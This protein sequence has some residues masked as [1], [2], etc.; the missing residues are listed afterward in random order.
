MQTHEFSIAGRHITT[1]DPD[2]Q[3]ALAEAR[4]TKVRPRCLCT[5]D[6]VEMYIASVGDHLIV[7]RMPMSG[8]GHAPGCDSYEPPPELSGLG[9][10][11]GAA[12]NEGTEETTLKLAF[13]LT[14]SGAGSPPASDSEPS[15]S[16][17]ADPAKLSMRA[18]VHYLWE[19]AEFN[20]WVPAMAGK[21]SWSVVR[22]HLLAA[23]RG[24]M[25]KGAPLAS[26]LYLPEPWND[27]RKT[28]LSARRAQ[29]MTA[30]SDT[31]KGR[32]RLLF[33]LAEVAAITEGRLGWKLMLAELPG[34]A[35]LLPD[36]LHK[37]MRKRFGV[38]LELWEADEQSRLIVA[39]TISANRAG[40]PTFHELTL[41][42][43]T[44][45]WIP[46]ESVTDKLLLDHLTDHRRTF[47]KGLR[48]NLADAKALAAAVL[49]DTT[50]ATALYLASGDQQR[51]AVDELI[52]ESDIDSWVWD[53]TAELPALP[54]ASGRG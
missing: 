44:E 54:P 51:Q 24:K 14:V 45:N 16:V 10:V 49:T 31:S 2:W 1:V 5:R 21:R 43:V 52:A 42:P 22:R 35:F 20:R 25:T 47:V 18:T 11:L 50:P 9:Q 19:Q 48:Y 12:I 32:Q 41:M 3:I 7:K 23:A 28:E 4:R 34:F 26:S 15:D 29:V 27:A 8:T 30:I 13:A 39:G 53:P 46:F 40:V 17:T 33:V 37:R 6:G 36:D 38:E